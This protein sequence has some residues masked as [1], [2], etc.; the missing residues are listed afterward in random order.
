VAGEERASVVLR[1]GFCT[2]F[3]DL[4][5]VA[6]GHLLV[7]PNVH[8]ARLSDL[9]AE[10]VTRVLQA[11]ADLLSVQRALGLAAEGANLLLNDGSAA[12]Q[13]VP[14]VHVHVVPRRPGDALRAIGTF[15]ARAAGVF[16]RPAR[17]ED[18]DVL[19]ARI[20]ESMPGPAER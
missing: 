13:H 19:A 8:A 5:P 12:N 15:A 4:F 17:R 3:L 9:P 10:T 6:P 14:H 2:A 16:G 1:D 11:A 7:V 20:R 18:L